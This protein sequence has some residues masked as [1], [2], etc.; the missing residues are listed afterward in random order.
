MRFTDIL[1]IARD[2]VILSA[3]STK[4]PQWQPSETDIVD[5]AFW[6]RAAFDLDE[7]V[8]FSS[9]SHRLVTNIRLVHTEERAPVLAVDDDPQALRYIRDTLAA[10]GFRPVVTGDPQEALA[11]MA[12][13]LPRLVLLD[14]VL[15]DADGIE[16]MRALLRIAD[17]PV[18]F[19]SAYGRDD[20]IARAFEA[21][22]VDYVVKPFSPT[23]LTARIRASLRR[24]A[25]SQ[26]LEPYVHGDLVIDFA[27][28][29]ATLGR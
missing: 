11:L 2:K 22:A 9:Y 7:T 10:A 28:R 27:Q 3:L 8:V 5:A 4:G 18:I 26:P 16:L 6:A 19:L 24:R 17:V 23:E 20:T 1:E 14:L 12:Q 15:P 29:R 13:H 21:G 25:A